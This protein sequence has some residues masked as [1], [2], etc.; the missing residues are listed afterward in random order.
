R[1][2]ASTLLEILASTLVAP[3]RMVSHVA[4]LVAAVTDTSMDWA[5]ARR[6]GA[7]WTLASAL[8]LH[9]HETFTG[10]MLAAALMRIDLALALWLSPIWF[11][12]VASIPIDALLSSRALGRK[13][14]S[15]GLFLTP[16]EEE[17]P[18]V[19]ARATEILEESAI[20]PCT[21]AE[22]FQ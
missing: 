12:L 9:G 6:E 1:V 8:R 3:M 15:A 22:R 10:V 21:F 11:G 14:R 13:L 7:H 17:T 19:I 16:A 18:P 2:F 4:C 20:E 5:A